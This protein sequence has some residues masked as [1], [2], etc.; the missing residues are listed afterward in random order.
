MLNLLDGLRTGCHEAST[1]ATPQLIDRDPVLAATPGT[2][3][4]YTEEG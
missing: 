4:S 1:A 3:Q 2:R